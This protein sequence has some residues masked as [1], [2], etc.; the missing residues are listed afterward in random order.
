MPTPGKNVNVAAAKV[1]IAITAVTW[2]IIVTCAVTASKYSVA[3]VVFYFIEAAALLGL[4]ITWELFAKRAYMTNVT[5]YVRLVV[6]SVWGALLIS[7]AVALENTRHA[8][9]FAITSPLFFA[10]VNVPVFFLVLNDVDIMYHS[11]D[12]HTT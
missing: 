4:W 5:R 8:F 2:I 7:A 10:P 6:G 1:A 12:L 9:D 11:A 3:A